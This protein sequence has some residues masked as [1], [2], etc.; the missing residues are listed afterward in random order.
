MLA[1][2][3]PCP[4]YGHIKHLCMVGYG[5]IGRALLPLIQTHFSF[6]H[7]TIYDSHSLVASPAS[8]NTTFHRVGLYPDTYQQILDQTVS[9][10]DSMI[11]NVSV[12]VESTSLI[13]YALDKDIFYVD[14][15]CEEWEQELTEEQKAT[16]EKSNY[17]LR[18]ALKN[19]VSNHKS[20]STVVSSCGCNPG[21]V[22]WFLK[23][24]LI[25]ITNGTG[26]K[27]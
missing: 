15:S 27:L 25:N 23:Q 3:H 16:E 10:N 13:E 24:A 18:E 7:M 17:A 4:N 8:P 2:E 21:L 19:R 11:I 22:S 1:Q 14:T 6:D 20:H 5:T 9:P 26:F 12:C